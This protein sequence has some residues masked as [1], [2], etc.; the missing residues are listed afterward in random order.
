MSEHSENKRVAVDRKNLPLNF[1]THRHNSEFWELLGRSVATFGFLEETLA[2][3]IFAFTGMQEVPEDQVESR[4]E[5]WYKTLEKALKDSLGGLI[6]AY[7]TAVKSHA[8]ADTG[9]FDKL[10]SAL[11][12]A[13]LIR[14]VVC[15]GAWRP[16]DAQGRSAPFFVDKKLRVFDD[17]VDAGYLRQVQRH[18]VEL[19][20]SVVDS[21]TFM[22]WQFPGSNGPGK[23]VW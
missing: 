5:E 20:C 15:H 9:D 3:A 6:S 22:G 10:V 12:E 8:K 2:K 4:L 13:A 11:R 19:I 21:V 1:P 23:A 7:A 18:T 16:P 17:R 14:N